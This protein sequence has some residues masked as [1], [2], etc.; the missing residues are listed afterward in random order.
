MSVNRCLFYKGVYYDVGTVVKLKTKWNEIK[1]TTFLGGGNYAG[2]SRY[3]YYFL[4]PPETYIVE[5]V[6]PVYYQPPQR[7]SYQKSSRF[8]LNDET[9]IGLIWY[10]VIMLIGI[11][12]KDRLLIWIVATIIFFGWKSQNN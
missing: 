10:I 7:D 9:A 3:G 11:I 2:I 6:T 12:F 1:T 8:T 5:I 4:E